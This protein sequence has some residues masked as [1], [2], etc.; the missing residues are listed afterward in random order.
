PGNLA[1]RR[2]RLRRVTILALLSRAIGIGP[3]GPHRLLDRIRVQPFVGCPFCE[4][5]ELAVGREAQSD[6]LLDRQTTVEQLAGEAVVT[7]LLFRAN[8]AVVRLERERTAEDEQEDRRDRERE[9]Q[10]RTVETR[11][12]DRF[13]QVDAG[14]DGGYQQ[15]ERQYDVVADHVP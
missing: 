8:G 3:P 14:A 2:G 13:H 15:Q 5:R 4:C 1:V 11:C 12:A 7:Q 10:R 9:D 6:D